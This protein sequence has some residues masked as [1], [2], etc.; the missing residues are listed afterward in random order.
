MADKNLVKVLKHDEKRKAEAKDEKEKEK[1]K[2][3]NTGVRPPMPFRPQQPYPMYGWPTPQ[4]YQPQMP[5]TGYAPRPETRTC[6]N[7]KQVGHLARFC[8]QR[9]GPSAALGAPPK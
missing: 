7:C 6:L 9:P 4:G 2:K 3:P 1:R 8:P 5:M